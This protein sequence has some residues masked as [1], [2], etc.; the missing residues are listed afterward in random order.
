MT[1]ADGI[2]A[3]GADALSQKE[4][5]LHA[6]PLHEEHLRLFPRD[7][8]IEVLDGGGSDAGR[9]IPAICRVAPGL[10]EA[11]RPL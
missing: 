7:A 8:A 9:T 11:G 2:V 4:Q 10:L 1:N 3:H 5:A 6:A